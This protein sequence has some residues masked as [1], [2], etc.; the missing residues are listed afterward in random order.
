MTRE[1]Q[2]I[3][4]EETP[5]APTRTQWD[6]EENSPEP[7]LLA[8][9]VPGRRV[10]P[11]PDAGIADAEAPP[12]E[13]PRRE[14]PAEPETLSTADEPWTDSLVSDPWA[15]AYED[16]G[17]EVDLAELESELEPEP[18]PEFEAAFE[19]EPAFEPEYEHRPEEGAAVGEPGQDE[20]VALAEVLEGLAARLRGD[21]AR[22]VEA[23][24]ASP[25]RITALL[26]GFLAGYLAG[27]GG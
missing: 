23:E 22:G 9:F 25:D 6:R 18:E 16:P 5:S 8:P 10:S 13:D 1:G 21:G 2:G 24:M 17:E 4:P 7:E 27:R 19:P 15:E 14:D 12:G 11:P 3:G 26:A 20:A